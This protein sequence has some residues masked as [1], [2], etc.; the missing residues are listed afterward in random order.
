MSPNDVQPMFL[1]LVDVKGVDTSVGFTRWSNKP[2]EKDAA[3]GVLLRSFGSQDAKRPSFN[4]SL[5]LSRVLV[6]SFLREA[7]AIPFVKTN[8]PQTMLAFE[9][10]NPLW[11]RSLNP[12]S[13]AHTPGGSSG[14]EAA[15]LAV[16]GSA[17]G[18]GSDIGGSLRIP[19]GY[20]G[21][22]SLKPG[23]ARTSM[24]GAAGQSLLL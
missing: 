4:L 16:D 9:C 21:I 15:L 5:S 20:C 24:E 7:G 23:Y 11:G 1:Y 8:V 14:G 22:Y 19:T 17:A 6:V 10:S 18:I 13:H 12:W 2:A 3:V